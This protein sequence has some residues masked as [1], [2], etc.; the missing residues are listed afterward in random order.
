MKKLTYHH[1][2]IL[3]CCSVWFVA[4]IG[5]WLLYRNEWAKTD[6]GL[7][8]TDTRHPEGMEYVKADTIK[9]WFP[10]HSQIKRR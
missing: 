9:N 8:V 4:I 2:L 7:K 1:K 6:R 5:R 3:I 10:N